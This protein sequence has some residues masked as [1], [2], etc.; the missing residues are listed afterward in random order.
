MK[1]QRFIRYHLLILLTGFSTASKTWLPVH[2][3]YIDVNVEAQCNEVDS[4]YNVYRSLTTLRNTSDA[5]KSGS[6][7]T[8]IISNTVLHVLRK[9][10]SEAV[11]LLINFSDEDKQ[12]VALTDTGNET[13][14]IVTASVGSGITQGWVTIYTPRYIEI[15][16]IN[17]KY[18]SVRWFR[19]CENLT[20]RV[21]LAITRQSKNI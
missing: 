16:S 21:Y 17:K 5:L 19:I 12:E 13:G 11:S 10:N 9:T 2:E 6:L 7:T 1:Y 20:L 14:V 18:I 15:V 3:S 8:D 4:H